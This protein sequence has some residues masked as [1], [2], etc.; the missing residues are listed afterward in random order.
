MRQCPSAVASRP[1]AGCARFRS[2]A[3]S[4][5][6]GI[7][8]CLCLLLLTVSVTA[9][10]QTTDAPSDS[11]K[12]V[13][14]FSAG[15][16]F[17]TPFEGGQPHLDPL[18][19]PVFLIPFGA[20]WLVESRD[21][22]ESDLSTVPGRSGYHGTVEK[23]VDYLQLDYIANPYLTVTV[24]RYLT[25]FGIYN[26]RLYPIWIRDLQSDPLILPLATG[27][28][29]AGTGAMARGGFALNQ[30]V[31]VNYAAYV[32]VLSTITRLDSDRVAGGR[33]GLFFPG[34][35]LEIGGS[36]QHL[37]QDDRSNAFGF[38]LEWQPPAIPLDVRSEYARSSQGSGYWIEPAYRLSQIPKAQD[39]FSRVQVVGRM[40]QYFTGVTPADD[41][42]PV[43]T[44][45]FEFGVNYYFRY[46]LR[47]VSSYGRQFSALGNENV[48]TVGVTYRF[49]LA[50][51]H[52]EI[53]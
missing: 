10:A 19:S 42:L 37:L 32:S 6:V 47:A 34:P 38:H 3:A 16:G 18:I 39:F 50:L 35:R 11:L 7:I 22:F 33:A 27:P 48:W 36:F 31:N 2:L 28:S 41:P 4:K 1:F 5:A 30:H 26:E 12:P 21:T 15:T 14:L 45:Q 17:I 24:G 40:Q 53:N 49:V 23:G 52:G 29:G 44:K 8:A 51:G 13:P 46:N 25:P 20:H 9:E 43:D